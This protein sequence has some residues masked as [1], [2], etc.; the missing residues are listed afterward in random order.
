MT[1]IRIVG[2]GRAGSSFEGALSGAGVEIR[3]VLH[4]FDALGAAAHGVDAVLLA[5]PDRTVADVAASIE[6]VASTVM[7]HCS[8]SLGLDVLAP[9]SR[10]GSLH[11]LVTL[12]DAIIGAL[13][14]RGRP[15]F[16]V[17]GDR[18]AT[19]LVLVLKGQ[20]IVVPDDLRAAYHAT[21]CVAA[22][23]LVG[24]LGQVQ[25]MAAAAGLPLEAFLP[26]ARGALDD[27]ALLGPTEALTG[28]ASRGDTITIE[29]HR[30]VIDRA[31]VLAYDAGVALA[32]RLAYERLGSR[33]EP[34]A[35]ASWS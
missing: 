21:A 12:P 4:R 28:P 18:L 3:E 22:N 7:L 8:G 2:G 15:F 10:V 1:S 14:L 33:P 20:P 26:L 19:D 29:R 11:P 16:A 6:P 34:S 35:H 27:V 23:H 30:A 31:E 5:V 25:R 13:R 17:A 24:L 32:E 9:H